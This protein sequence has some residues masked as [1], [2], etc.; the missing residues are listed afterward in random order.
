MQAVGQLDQDD[1]D[2]VDHG[3]HHLA[4]VFCLLL[5][6]GG[7]VDLADFGDAFDD[8]SYL[9]TEFFADVD[10]GDGGVFDGIVQQ[11]GGYGH[12]VHFHFRQHQC[13]L[14]TDEPDTARLRP[15]VCPA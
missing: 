4:Q 14:Q 10:D 9:L 6:A 8:V 15:V 1:A 7:E 13:Y 11:A 3:Q 12:G 5:F 2:V